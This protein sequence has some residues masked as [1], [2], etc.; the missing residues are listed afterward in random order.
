MNSTEPAGLRPPEPVPTVRT[1]RN[2]GL[3]M[4]SAFGIVAGITWWGGRAAAPW[5]VT[6]A[7]L[8]LATGL[9]R[10]R[11]LAPLERAWMRLAL[12]LG[13]VTNRVILTI[14]FALMITPVGVIRRLLRRDSLG[15]RF[16]R[17]L[18]TYWIPVDP[19]GPVSRPDKPY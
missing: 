17:Q 18:P 7:I 3:V 9:A 4:A 2:F 10:P 13:F 6:V 14:T 5:L 11:W 12:A 16:D 15:L 1:L 8:F 19:D